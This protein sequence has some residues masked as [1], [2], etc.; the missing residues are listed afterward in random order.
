MVSDIE[1]EAERIRRAYGRRAERGLDSRYEYRLP[2]NLFT[3][4]SRERELVYLLDGASL[5]P[6]GDRKVLDAGCGDG[7]VLRDLVR[8]GSN[9]ACLTGVDLLPGRVEQARELT[10]GAR[11]EVA[12]AQMLPF[13]DGEFGLVLGFTLLSSVTDAAARRRVAS[14]MARVC[15][16]HGAIVLYDFWINPFNRDARPL[17]RDEVRALFAG[18]EASFRSVTLAMPLARALAPLPGGRLACTLL[19]MIPFLRT[20]FLVALRPPTPLP[21]GAVAAEDP[22][23]G[24]P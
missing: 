20:H 16:A 12:D 22:R 15:G 17:R 2:A 21:T 7:G 10:P 5:L 18:W 24:Q 11:F 14:E 4:Q 23:P 1:R 19:E 9:P 13:G 6:L 8:L 3:Y